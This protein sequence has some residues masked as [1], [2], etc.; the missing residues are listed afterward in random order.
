MKFNRVPKHVGI[1]LD[2]NRTFAKRL[3]LK[4]WKGHEWGAR[5]VEKLLEWCIELKIKELTL[6]AFSIYNFNRPK[7]EFDFLMNL[8]EKEF[9]RIKND[10][11]IF[12]NKIKLNFIGRTWM[13][14]EKVQKEMKE[15]VKLTK[16]HDNLIVNFAMAYGG[17]TE[18]I[19]AVKKIAEQ[20]KE[21][22]LDINKINEE[23]FGKN[24]Y[25][26][27][28]V[29][30]IVRT[31]GQIRTSDFLPWQGANAEWIFIEKCWPE[32][33]KEDFIKCIKEYSNRE[34]RFGR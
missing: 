31:S 30:L 23:T 24:L 34:R 14:P 3:M 9:K 27:D 20:V 22:E 1:I 16:N 13:F 7:K 6:Y 17:K 11:R 26:N 15:L 12:K 28:N 18:V 21:G 29:D 8:F 32:F 33:E 5:K 2:G 4:P 25:L 19:D 10:E